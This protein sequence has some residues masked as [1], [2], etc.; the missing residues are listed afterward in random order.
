MIAGANIASRARQGLTLIE[1]VSSMAASVVL[2]AG[3]AAAVGVSVRSMAYA[4]VVSTTDSVPGSGLG[5]LQDDLNDATDVVEMRADGLTIVVPDRT[6]DSVA[7]ELVYTIAGNQLQRSE[8]GGAPAVIADRLSDASFRADGPDASQNLEFYDDP[9]DRGWVQDIRTIAS[10][11]TATTLQIPKPA[12]VTP[13]DLLV[14][15]VGTTGNTS[16]SLAA[17]A[18]WTPLHSEALGDYLTIGVW[19]RIADGSEEPTMLA[20][21]STSED[22]CGWMMRISGV[23]AA[24]PISSS[25]LTE[26]TAYSY[27]PLYRITGDQYLDQPNLLNVRFVFATDDAVFDKLALMNGF[28]NL[29]WV[30]SPSG[31]SRIETAIATRHESVFMTGTDGGYYFLS[32]SS[33]YIACEMLVAPAGG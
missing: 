7:E 6:G 16:S 12:G 24:S 13:G 17:A 20:S 4:P 27:F 22:A 25:E 33:Y 1:L 26:G 5:L 28:S 21:W 30:E 2:V 11:G 15:A 3:I 29:D 23:N 19:Y 9:H 31:S 8:N 18:G 14:A 32:G 10:G